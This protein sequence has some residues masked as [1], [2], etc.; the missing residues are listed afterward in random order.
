[1]AKKNTIISEI[2]S[3]GRFAYPF[4]I[5]LFG[6]RSHM[7]LTGNLTRIQTRNRS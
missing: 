4:F 1:V 3:F 7:C 2:P 6:G 5:N